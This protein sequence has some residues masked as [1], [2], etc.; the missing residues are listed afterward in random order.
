MVPIR[1]NILKRCRK[2]GQGRALP[3]WWEDQVHLWPFL[4]PH[5]TLLFAGL[6]WLDMMFLMC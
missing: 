6:G 1:K 3:C 2:E 5:V 4:V